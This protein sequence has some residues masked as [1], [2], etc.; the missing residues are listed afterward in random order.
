M[1][2]AV[3]YDRYAV[4]NTVQDAHG[5]PVVGSVKFKKVC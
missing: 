4:Y 3:S 5:K 2:T 1:I